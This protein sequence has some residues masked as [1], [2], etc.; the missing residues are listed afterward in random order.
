MY[1][2][3]TISGFSCKSVFNIKTVIFIYRI[4]NKMA[5]RGTQANQHRI[6]YNKR[7]NSIRIGI[8]SRY[9]NMPSGQIN[10]IKKTLISRLLS[11][12]GKG[13]Q[14]NQDNKIFFHNENFKFHNLIIKS[15][16]CIHLISKF[17]GL[18]FQKKVN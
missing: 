5:S 14:K 2:D 15:G 3:T 10:S 8:H 7:I 4:G 17:Y 18:F 13:S 11:L 6:A 12:T 9:I 16:C 1:E